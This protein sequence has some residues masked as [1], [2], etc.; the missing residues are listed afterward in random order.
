MS[1]EKIK[2]I[3]SVQLLDQEGYIIND[4]SL[5]NLQ[6]EYKDI[7]QQLIEMYQYHFG[8]YLHSIYLRG[9]VAKGQAIPNLSD[10]DTVAISHQK[11]TSETLKKREVIWNTLEN[12]Y[13]FV[14]GVEIHFE[15][16]EEVMK[17]GNFQFL[18]KTQCVF[19]F[20]KNIIPELPKFKI[21]KAAYPHSP[22]L[23]KDLE[24][25]MEWLKDE[26]DASEIK[27]ICMWIMKRV[28]RVGFELVMER[29]ACFTRDLYPSFERFSKHYPIYKTPMLDALELAV[30]PTD[31]KGQIKEVL[32]AIVPF[33]IQEIGN[34]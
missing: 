2:N 19:I 32:D 9:S 26:D 27:D 8:D 7:L 18:L 12:K 21:G 23:G 11:L 30:F 1:K 29:E 25:T 33:L 17:S 3:G 34:S 15:S 14:K 5:D 28:V 4:L 6:Q 24:Q 20:G 31:H 22:T 16:L 10:L 13:P